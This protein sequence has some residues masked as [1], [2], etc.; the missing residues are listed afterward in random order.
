M[1]SRSKAPELIPINKKEEVVKWHKFLP[2]SEAK[3]AI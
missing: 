1:A 2:L 3:A